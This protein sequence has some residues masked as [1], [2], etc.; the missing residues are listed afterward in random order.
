VDTNCRTGPGIVYDRIG[1][2]KVGENAEVVGKRTSHNYWIIKNPDADGNCWLW[3]KYAIIS[4][5]TSN[6]QEYSVPQAPRATSPTTSS[7]PTV[8]VSVGT[9]CRT[10]PGKAYF[11]VGGLRVGETA[12]VV[13]KKT[14]YNYWIIKNPDA[15]GDC[16]LWG[17]YA[18]VAGN[19]S[20]LPEYIVP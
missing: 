3:G 1:V 18:T 10:G 13:G 14:S 5:N 8:R 20:N 12:E 11:I 17:Y 9:N 15:S 19:T 7:A 4:G 16:W 2:F 6:L